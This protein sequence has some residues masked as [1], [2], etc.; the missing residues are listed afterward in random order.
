MFAMTPVG[1]VGVMRGGRLTVWTGGKRDQGLSLEEIRERAR[2]GVCGFILGRNRFKKNRT[3]ISALL[4]ISR[5]PNCGRTH[6]RNTRNYV[7]GLVSQSIW[8]Q[9]LTFLQHLL[10][11][12]LDETG[13]H[14][15]NQQNNQTTTCANYCYEHHQIIYKKR[16]VN[17]NK[18][19][20]RAHTHA[21]VLFLW[22]V[23]VV[24]KWM[25]GQ[26]IEDLKGHLIGNLI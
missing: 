3:T 14:E 24:I 1:I 10:A 8:R 4:K 15:N 11:G 18:G 2:F 5:T 17:T 21:R 12:V 13:D 7:S 22:T 9:T 20:A 16:H 23:K 6:G 26:W 19:E 25:R